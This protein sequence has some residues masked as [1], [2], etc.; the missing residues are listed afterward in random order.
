MK[1]EISSSSSFLYAWT[2]LFCSID[3]QMA[4]CDSL[5]SERMVHNLDSCMDPGSRF[6]GLQEE[7]AVDGSCQELYHLGL[8][9]FLEWGLVGRSRVITDGRGTVGEEKLRLLHSRQ[10]HSPQSQLHLRPPPPSAQLWLLAVPSRGPANEAS[11]TVV[12]EAPGCPQVPQALKALEVI[13]FLLYVFCY[14]S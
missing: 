7:L 13:A 11:L 6:F 1:L 3:P 9:P 14:I 8:W 4:S 10:V 2:R 5:W 12:L